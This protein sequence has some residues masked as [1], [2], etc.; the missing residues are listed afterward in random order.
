MQQ[1]IAARWAAVAGLIVTL[2][3]AKVNQIATR[4]GHCDDLGCIQ[5]ASGPVR[6]LCY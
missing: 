2:L 3:P 5:L 1:A 6:S 4:S